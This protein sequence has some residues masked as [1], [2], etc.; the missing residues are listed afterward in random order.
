MARSPSRSGPGDAFGGGRVTRLLT[1]HHPDAV[2]DPYPIDT[3]DGDGPGSLLEAV[4]AEFDVLV[5]DA[6]GDTGDGRWSDRYRKA[7]QARAIR[8][9]IGCGE[10]R[11]A[12]GVR[13]T[14][15]TEKEGQ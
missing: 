2:S 4:R 1:I 6:A 3:V 13:W 12:L 7:E 11:D 14:M 8:A 15:T 9:L 10:Y 5:D